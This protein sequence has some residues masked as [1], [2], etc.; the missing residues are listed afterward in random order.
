MKN[1]KNP[2][3]IHQAFSFV[4]LAWMIGPWFFWKCCVAHTATEEAVTTH[5]KLGEAFY[6]EPLYIPYTTRGIAEH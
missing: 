1:R 6:W 4:Q 2:Q 5:N 3:N